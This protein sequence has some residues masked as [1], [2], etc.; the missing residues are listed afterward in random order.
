MRSP[1]Q[2]SPFELLNGTVCGLVGQTSGRGLACSSSAR[3]GLAFP[4]T[5]PRLQA[6]SGGL[7]LRGTLPK[8]LAFLKLPSMFLISYLLVS[9][10]CSS[11]LA[12]SELYKLIQKTPFIH[13][14]PMRTNPWTFP[15]ILNRVLFPPSLLNGW[16]VSLK[17]ETTWRGPTLEFSLHESSQEMAK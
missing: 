5:H 8:F 3:I 17:L 9:P 2:S 12:L 11:Q 15:R 16:N 4:G 13:T 10:L 7:Y 14:S 6:L 1:G